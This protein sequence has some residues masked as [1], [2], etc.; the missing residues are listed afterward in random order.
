MKVV[1]LVGGIFF[2]IGLAMLIGTA[3]L[4]YSQNDFIATAKT[5]QGEVIDMIRRE[6]RDDGT[7]SYTYAAVVRFSD[8]GGV[9]QEFVNRHS[10]NPP[11]Y[12]KGEQV[13][14][15]YAPDNPGDAIIDDFWG[16]WGIVAI[17]G[18]TG[19]IFSL[20]GG[21]LLFWFIRKAQ[22]K[23]WLRANG[24]P[25]SIDFYS[26]ERDTST[27]VNGRHPF[28]VVAQGKNPFTGKLE[29][30]RSESIWVDPTAEL[31]GTKMKVF[32]DPNKPSR[33][34]VDVE[35]YLDAD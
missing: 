4:F 7:T 28:C 26:V 18:F 9:S 2:A 15:L 31:Q 3:Y 22:I 6:S 21:G 11:G 29:Q 16:R 32:I 20:V 12:S 34:S 8:D 25:I 13:Q 33:H 5:A 30:F 24:T 10:S 23:K 14:V 17:L 27:T 19:S 35:R 1:K